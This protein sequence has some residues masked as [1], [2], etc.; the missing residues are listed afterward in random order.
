MTET[1]HFTNDFGHSNSRYANIWYV[2]G[3]L[4]LDLTDKIS[5]MYEEYV[6]SLNNTSEC[7]TISSERYRVLMTQAQR[8]SGVDIADYK[9]HN[10]STLSYFKNA[11]LDHILEGDVANGQIIINL[12]GFLPHHVLTSHRI[13]SDVYSS[14]EIGF[15][16]PFPNI[17]SESALRQGLAE[18]PSLAYDN[19]IHSLTELITYVA[20]RTN[21]IKIFTSSLGTTFAIDSLRKLQDYFDLQKKIKHVL[22]INGASSREEFTLPDGC[23]EEMEYHINKVFYSP[24]SPYPKSD[25]EQR[26]FFEWVYSF[27]APVNYLNDT[28]ILIDDNTNVTVVS[29]GLESINGS[30]S[31]NPNVD[32][33]VRTYSDNTRRAS[34]MRAIDGNLY[35]RLLPFA[36]TR[37]IPAAPNDN[38]MA[39]LSRGHYLSR[40]DAIKLKAIINEI[41]RN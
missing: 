32:L 18:V 11:S 36:N 8:E 24:E 3:L 17:P 25:L 21:D 16:G 28:P 2:H 4:H 29:T 22:I 15:I 34:L 12:A 30:L 9:C 26:K 13:A 41:V 37:F 1:I 38:R 14:P 39:P 10:G 31:C 23:L 5:T 20:E 40:S 19:H 6:D 7:N 33:A 27:V 35:L